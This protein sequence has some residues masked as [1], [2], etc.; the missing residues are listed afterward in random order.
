[1]SLSF[2]GNSFFN[3]NM[4][5]SLLIMWNRDKTLSTLYWD[6]VGVSTYFLKLGMYCPLC[7][8]VV[9]LSIHISIFL[10]LATVN[11]L[12]GTTLGEGF[13]PFKKTNI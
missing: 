1:M 3:Y 9:G 6:K 2:F 8:T 12:Y 10:V 5:E 11:T 7:S 13:V 4:W